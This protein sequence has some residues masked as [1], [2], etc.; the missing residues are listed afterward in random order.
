MDRFQRCDLI[1][2]VGNIACIVIT[3]EALP[4]HL[5]TFYR[6]FA[7]SGEQFDTSQLF[8]MIAVPQFLYWAIPALVRSSKL[9]QYMV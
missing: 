6:D 2:I 9:L 3:V 7:A 4:S 1:R 5:L 8:C